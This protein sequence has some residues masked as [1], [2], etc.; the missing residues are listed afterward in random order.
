[1]TEYI[2]KIIGSTINLIANISPSYAAKLAVLLFSK[3]RNAKLNDEALEYLKNTNHEDL[4]YKGFKIRTYQWYGKKETI[5]LVHGW[6]SNSFRWKDLI[7]LLKKENYNIISIDAPAHGASESKIFN[8]PLYSEFINEAIKKFNPSVIIGHSVGATATI[9]AQENHNISSTEKLILLGA[10]SNLGISVGNYV[11]MMG[12]SV[13]VAKAINNYYLKHFNQLP[14]Y[15]CAEN[16]C[17]NIQAKGLIIHDKKDN[18][19]SFKEALDIH[20]IYKNSQL[21][22]TIGFGHRLKSGKV[23][24]HIL[25]FLKA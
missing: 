25:D 17:K 21:I 12:Y 19:I 4:F 9:I 23:Y 1:M 15:Y 18:I 24:Q 14:K 11:K 2:T 3:P 16:F 22:K 7:E 20:R 6:D 8:A 10:P 13:K 5:L